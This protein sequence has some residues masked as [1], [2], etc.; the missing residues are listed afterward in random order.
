MHK[1]GKILIVDD[2]KDILDALRM[3]LQF[4]FDT[5]VAIFNP[6][7]LPFVLSK[8]DFDII[9]LDMNF[10][11]AIN[12]GNEGLFWLSE[13]K[14][15]SP[16]SEVIMITAYGD[17]ELSVKALKNG[18]ADFVVKPWENE[19]LLATIRSVYRFR[20]SNLELIDMKLRERSLK[21]ELSSAPEMIAG[22]SSQMQQVMQIVAKVSDTSANI[23]ITG[24]NGTGKEVLAQEI[25]KRSQ[26][27][28]EVFFKVDLGAIPET[29]FESELFG[30]K[31][32]SFTDAFEDRIGKLQLASKGTL[33]LDE[34]GNLSLPMQSKLLSAIENRK[35]TP[36]GSN[37]SVA[38]DSRIIS[39]TNCQIDEMTLHKSF[40]AD[41]LYRL[42]T[43]HIKLPPLRE[44]TEDIKILATHFLRK[45]SGKYG[46]SGM[47]LS[48]L[49]LNQLVKYPW[50]GNIRELQHTI[51]RAVI[52]A[53]TDK[54][55]PDDFMLKQAEKES[56][57]LPTLADMERNLIKSTLRRYDGNYTGTAQHL[58]IARQSLYNK[59]KKYGI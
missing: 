55:T 12:S 36:V 37:N 22:T 52:L 45:Y 34:I 21:E 57:E 39:A 59:I 27:A 6:N 20:K 19:K 8:N 7:Q 4:E 49:G 2:D 51:E 23:L 58:G 54:L 56:D 25:H 5:V 3:L 16:D 24:E 30:H 29:L 14:K 53:T 48:K 42:N 31:K 50:P 40:R 35:I 43:I 38:I 46:K 10:C 9:L 47:K 41:L 26:R 15:I 44:R 11:A 33:F 32:G 13:A 17:I 28:K 18:A 1:E